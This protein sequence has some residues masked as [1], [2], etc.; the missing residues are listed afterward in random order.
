MTIADSYK[1]CEAVTRERA[2]NFYYG[3]K[4][5][6]AEKR[7][8]LCAAYAFFRYCDDISDGDLGL[9]QGGASRG[10][11]AVP[12]LDQGREERLARWR[13][14]VDAA[15]G[16][17][18]S[19]L[20]PAFHDTVAK[21]AIPLRY[22]YELIEGAKADLSKDR[23]ETFEELY[24]YCYNVASTVGLVCVHIFG[25]DGSPEALQMAEQ[26]GI[27]FQLTNILRDVAEDLEL[28]R[29]YLP[30]EDLRRFGVSEEKLLR[31][32]P[33]AGFAD[34]V[35]FEVERAREYYR[36]SDPLLERVDAVSRPSL[37]AMTSI[38]RE[39]L[40][41]VSGLGKEVLHKRAALS[42]LEKLKLA[43]Q[44]LISTL[45]S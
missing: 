31:K 42:K 22:F 14:A 40:E 5:L 38:Y 30:A 17:D 43:G 29:V 13:A 45:R 36:L 9:E 27:A 16:S 15:G 6:P 41:K 12:P 32:E 39:V 24:G 2:Q 25:F 35:Q 34:L 44:T 7:Q 4:L 20:L 37:K 8:S 21:Y 19:P 23:Y 28:G 11:G 1:H 3:I 10:G 33:E 18:S 26:R